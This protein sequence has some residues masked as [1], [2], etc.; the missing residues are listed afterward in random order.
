[1][2]YFYANLTELLRIVWRNISIS[3]RVCL[4]SIQIINLLFIPSSPSVKIVGG[5]QT[6]N[7][8]VDVVLI[9]SWLTSRDISTNM[10]GERVPS[11]PLLGFK[12]CCANDQVPPWDKQT[13][14]GLCWEYQIWDI[15]HLIS[16]L[17]VTD[18][19]VVFWCLKEKRQ[20]SVQMYCSDKW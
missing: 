15:T 11:L 7:A 18:I 2:K 10:R 14:S 9:F 6:K 20:V 1:M 4:S 19:L 12:Y 3:G 5:D 17:K 16:V 13:D 8:Q